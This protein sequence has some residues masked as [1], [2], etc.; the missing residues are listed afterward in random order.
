MKNYD[1]M[2]IHI[3]SEFNRIKDSDELA[4]IPCKHLE[5]GGERHAGAR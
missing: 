5:S 3:H 4:M 2:H 1:C